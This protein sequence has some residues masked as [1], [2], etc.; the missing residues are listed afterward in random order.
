MKPKVP[1]V[2]FTHD[3]MNKSIFKFIS[4]I[5]GVLREVTIQSLY[6]KDDDYQNIRR[7]G[8]TRIVFSETS[9]KME[10]QHLKRFQELQG[11]EYGN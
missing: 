8:Y 10:V 3:K 11:I 4:N 6:L 5:E 1:Y 2:I 9:V 7:F